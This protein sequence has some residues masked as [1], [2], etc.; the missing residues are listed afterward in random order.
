M[1]NE[2]N[3]TILY[4]MIKGFIWHVVN[5]EAY[6]TFIHVTHPKRLNYE[7]DFP[8]LT[9]TYDNGGDDDIQKLYDET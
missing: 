3:V 9:T 1:C 2:E 8:T 4:I 5:F 7:L 6:P